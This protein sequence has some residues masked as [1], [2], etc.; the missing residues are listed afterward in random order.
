MLAQVSANLCFKMVEGQPAPVSALVQHPLQY[1]G[2]L[3]WFIAGN[4]IGFFCT[5][6]LTLALK[7]HSPN[8]IYALCFGGGFFF[9]QLSSCVLFKSTLTLWQWF[10]ICLIG[11][12]IILLQLAA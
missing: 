7:D 9:L 3:G 5:V 2:P 11:S 8:V 4:L 12:G 10:A 6:F 1:A